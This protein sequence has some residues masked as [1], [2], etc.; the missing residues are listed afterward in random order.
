MFGQPDPKPIQLVDGAY[1]VRLY[2]ILNLGL[3]TSGKYKTENSRTIF[4]FETL[5]TFK[6]FD[7]AIG[8]QPHG[9]RSV[10]FSMSICLC[11]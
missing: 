11:N 4:C 6:I 2:G 10:F 8:P 3:I 1:N 9:I 5:D 7:D